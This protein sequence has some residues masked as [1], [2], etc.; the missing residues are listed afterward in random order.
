MEKTL[1]YN[2]ILEQTYLSDYITVHRDSESVYY[3]RN[4]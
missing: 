1:L 3:T 4:V 2:V